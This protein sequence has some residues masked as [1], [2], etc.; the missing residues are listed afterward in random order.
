MRA[1]KPTLLTAAKM[2][3]T[4][5]LIAAIAWTVGVIQP[6]GSIGESQADILD[7][8]FLKLSNSA[9]VAHALQQLG[10]D[11][12][13]SLNINGNVVHFSVNH[14]KKRPDQL[15]REY[16]EEFVRQGL[17]TRVWDNHNT[18]GNT[19]EMILEGM[20][21]GVIPIESTPE[22]VALGGVVTAND[23]EDDE[24]L[25][26]M[27]KDSTPANEVFKGHQFIEMYW[28]RSK[29]ASTVTATWSD[30]KFDYGKMLAGADSQQKDIDVD[31]LVPACPGCTRLSRVR[32][33]DPSREYSSNSYASTRA[34]REMV[35]FYRDAMTKRGW[36]ETDSSL[37]LDTIRPNVRHVG[38][39]A[40][41]MQFS[42]GA[43][44]LTVMAYPDKD[45]RTTVHTVMSD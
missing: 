6:D 25:L 45:G 21:G 42:K 19:D 38:D 28:D 3:G 41:L 32:D 20:T 1:P 16:Q 9:K 17:N 14:E 2:V 24:Q 44:F 4:A 23:A 13:Q 18:R 36:E 5:A 34:Q 30:E 22:H 15:M 29:R 8:S 26:E 43:R 11:E 27:A 39:E 31:P 12:P 7:V 35:G 33:L 40:T 37:V 10:H